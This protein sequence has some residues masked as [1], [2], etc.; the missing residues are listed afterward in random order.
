VS[1]E[2][3]SGANGVVN[4]TTTR[5]STDRERS[6]SAMISADQKVF[7]GLRFNDLLVSRKIIVEPGTGSGGSRP[8]IGRWF[9]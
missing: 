9:P 1:S 3:V 8:A 4:V 2:H 5:A 6:A 7:D